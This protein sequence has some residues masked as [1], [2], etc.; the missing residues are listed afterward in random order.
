MIKCYSVIRYQDIWTIVS[1]D[2]G[3]DLAEGSVLKIIGIPADLPQSV[4]S[5]NAKTAVTT[6]QWAKCCS[7]LRKRI[8]GITQ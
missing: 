1:C 6:K 2:I 3:N 4:A 5:R 8:R 7:K